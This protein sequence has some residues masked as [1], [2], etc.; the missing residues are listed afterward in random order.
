LP[1]SP[2]QRETPVTGD[3]IGKAAIYRLLIDA[4]PVFTLRFQEGSVT[5]VQTEHSGDVNQLRLIAIPN[6]DPDA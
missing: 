3:A 5:E 4:S 1:W 6:S 2:L